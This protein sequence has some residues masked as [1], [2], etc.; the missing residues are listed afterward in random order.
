MEKKLKIFWKASGKFSF[1]VENSVEYSGSWFDW[2]IWIVWIN[3]FSES[4][5]SFHNNFDS[6]Q[7]Y[8]VFIP[9]QFP[10]CN[11][12]R[13]SLLT[14]SESW[15]IPG[16]FSFWLFQR[17]SICVMKNFPTILKIDGDNGRK[18]FSLH[19]YTWLIAENPG[20]K[21]EKWWKFFDLRLEEKSNGKRKNWHSNDSRGC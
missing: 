8:Q 5:K 21:F 12:D 7:K 6:F 19:S 2:K 14:F 18:M 10:L 11:F 13:L 9:F 4:S 16:N 1:L 17:T 3:N 20:H 15:T